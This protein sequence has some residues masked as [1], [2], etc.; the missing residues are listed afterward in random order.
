[1]YVLCLKTYNNRKKERVAILNLTNREQ[2]FHML[3]KFI[4][5]IYK[6]CGCFGF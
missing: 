3:I 1:M 5:I 4:Y 6:G 2:G